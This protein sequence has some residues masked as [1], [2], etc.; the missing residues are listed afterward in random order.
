[1][2]TTLPAQNMRACEVLADPG[3]TLSVSRVPGPRGRRSSGGMGERSA[4]IPDQR[5]RSLPGGRA[6]WTYGGAH[7]ARTRP[8]AC[9][10]CAGPGLPSL[11][12]PGQAQE[13]PQLG[14][15]G[16][17]GGQRVA[18]ARRR[19]LEHRVKLHVARAPRQPL[20]IQCRKCTAVHLQTQGS[21]TSRLWQL[22]GAG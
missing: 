4:C 17:R 2:A 11:L 18:H 3:Q 22:T 12:L 5:S 10:H 20:R 7:T 21:V 14:Q 8:R 6:T 9:G 16:R 19:G 1:M 15:R 13:L